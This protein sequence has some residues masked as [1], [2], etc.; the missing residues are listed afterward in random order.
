MS[1]RKT[2]SIIVFAVI[3]IGLAALTGCGGGSDTPATTG[4]ST[5]STTSENT[6]VVFGT[7]PGAKYVTTTPTMTVLP[8]GSAAPTGMSAVA[9]ATVTST[10]GTTTTTDANGEFNVE[11]AVS[12]DT[13]T[14]AQTDPTQQPDV[15]VTATVNGVKTTASAT[16]PLANKASDKDVPVGLKVVP[17]EF[18]AF[19]NNQF[20]FQ[21]LRTNAEGKVIKATNVTWEM[22]SGTCAGATLAAQTDTAFAVLKTGAT[23]GSCKVKASILDSNKNAT[24]EDTAVGD[25][26]SDADAVTVA[27]MAH[28]TAGV[29]WAKAAVNLDCVPKG[30]A[31]DVRPVH[32]VAIADAQGMA[33]VKVFNKKLDATCRVSLG[34]PEPKAG[35]NN[36]YCSVTGTAAGKGADACPPGSTIAVGAANVADQHIFAIKAIDPKDPNTQIVKPPAPLERLV[37]MAWWETQES[38]RRHLFDPEHLNDLK[39]FVKDPTKADS[40]SDKTIDKGPFTGW[41]YALTTTKSEATGKIASFSLTMTDPRKVEK[42]VIACSAGTTEGTF[43][44]TMEI[45]MAT[46]TA[47]A[48]VTNS[49]TAVLVMKGKWTETLDTAAADP[50]GTKLVGEANAEIEEYFPD[51]PGKVAMRKKIKII[52]KYASSSQTINN[53][54][55]TVYKPSTSTITISRYRSDDTS[56]VTAIGTFTSTRTREAGDFDPN[57]TTVSKVVSFTGSAEDKVTLPDGVTT[58]TF[59]NTFDGYINSDESGKFTF[60]DK[61]TKSD[62]TNDVS[63]GA[64]VVVNLNKLTEETITVGS[65]SVKA[66]L[67]AGAEPSPCIVKVMDA[68]S[69]LQKIATF[70]VDIKGNVFITKSS[71]NTTQQVHL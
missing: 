39:R 43:S 60:T 55:V 64:E 31:P 50:D 18:K 29:A 13:K 59:K 47:T 7:V 8:D 26:V 30:A 3:T 41:T 52:T 44:C 70:K 23:A 62:G 42:R 66:M 65:T 58:V 51:A 32:F 34:V 56:L 27:A 20:F 15:T 2:V 5:S 68:A 12:S 25:I 69:A 1:F 49:T 17:H 6:F 38:R 10:D 37:R 67:V 46:F 4:S 21:A 61:T 33:T 54:T 22:V 40:N 35:Q 48:D 28:D 24:A 57:A 16:C 53:Q 14:A 11:N 9:G 63:F 45:Y 71:D 36:I 19:A